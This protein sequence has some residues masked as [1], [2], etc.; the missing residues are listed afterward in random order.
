MSL[1]SSCALVPEMLLEAP[2]EAESLRIEDLLK[3]CA[4]VAFVK[5]YRLGCIVTIR[6]GQG[7]LIKRKED[8]SW[9]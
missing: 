1:A 5:L 6:G 9:R 8:G 4:G 2:A 7:V 3:S